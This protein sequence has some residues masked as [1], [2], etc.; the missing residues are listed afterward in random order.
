MSQAGDP[1][2]GAG[3]YVPPGQTTKTVQP[4]YFPVQDFLRFDQA[5]IEAITGNYFRKY[6]IVLFKIECYFTLKAN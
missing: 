1:Y 4:S 2:T 3:R 6:F 5:N